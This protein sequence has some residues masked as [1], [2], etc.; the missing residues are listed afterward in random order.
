MWMNTSKDELINK[1]RIKKEWMWMDTSEDEL[2][3]K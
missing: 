2:I 1:L 3:N